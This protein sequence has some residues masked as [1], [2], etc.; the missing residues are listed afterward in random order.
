[1]NTTH[2]ILLFIVATS[3]FSLPGCSLL[4]K[5]PEKCC[6]QCHRDCGSEVALKPIIKNEFVCDDCKYLQRPDS[7]SGLQ[8]TPSA[9][10]TLPPV[11]GGWGGTGPDDRLDMLMMQVAQMEEQRQADDH[12]LKTLSRSMESMNQELGT[13]SV[14]VQYWK[15]EVQRVEGATIAQQKSDLESIETLSKLVDKIPLAPVRKYR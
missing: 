3:L 9:N 5:K 8:N 2:R 10:A 7:V 4:H 11:A 13:L 6:S 12:S 15:S 1:M 14:E